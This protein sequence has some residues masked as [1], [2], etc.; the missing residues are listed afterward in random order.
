MEP[1]VILGLCLHPTKH[2]WGSCRSFQSWLCCR[3]VSFPTLAETCWKSNVLQPYN[4]N[5]NATENWPDTG[6]RTLES[7]WISGGIPCLGGSLSKWQQRGVPWTS[8]SLGRM[9][10]VCCDVVGVLFEVVKW[11]KQTVYGR[12]IMKYECMRENVTSHTSIHPQET[13]LWNRVCCILIL[14]LAFPQWT[15]LLVEEWIHAACSQDLWSRNMGR[16]A[17]TIFHLGG[18]QFCL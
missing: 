12:I 16:V 7:E 15:H 14:R 11:K 18:I 5:W 2:T 3:E 4:N 13:F 8:H 17:D 1:V 10:L 6:R 9:P